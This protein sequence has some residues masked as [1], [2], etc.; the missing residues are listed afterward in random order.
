MTK[1]FDGMS[2]GVVDPCFGASLQVNRALLNDFSG[3]GESRVLS[4]CMSDGKMRRLL[5]RI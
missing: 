5:L 4:D 2:G 1:T 3:H